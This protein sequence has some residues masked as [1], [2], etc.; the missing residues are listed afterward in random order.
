M[1]GHS[2]NNFMNYAGDT[3]PEIWDGNI[4]TGVA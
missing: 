4:K 3:I 1:V 2:E